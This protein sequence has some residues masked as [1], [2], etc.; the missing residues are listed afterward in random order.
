MSSWR[1]GPGKWGPELDRLDGQQMMIPRWPAAIALLVLLAAD[2]GA[3]CTVSAGAV[4]SALAVSRRGRVQRCR[5]SVP[6]A[7]PTILGATAVCQL[8]GSRRN[9]LRLRGGS[10]LDACL[11]SAL[12]RRL[13]PTRT[14]FSPAPLAVAVP[15]GS[16]APPA[17]LPG[18]TVPRVIFILGGPGAGKG[19]QCAKL[20]EYYHGVKHLSAGD[21][22]R[23]ER[24]SGSAQGDMINSYM[25]EGKI[26]PVA[27]TAGLLK[28][29]IDVEVG[30]GVDLFL[31]DGFPRNE[32]NLRGW[33]EI[34]GDT[35]QVEFMLLM[36]CSEEVMME[37]L[38]KRGEGSGRVDDNSDTIRK[39]FDV[40][41]SETM[42]VVTYFNHQDRLQR[43][44]AD[45]TVETVFADI[46]KV[47]APVARSKSLPRRVAGKLGRFLAGLF[48]LP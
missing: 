12:R 2:A 47:M 37:R 22:L 39:R 10:L 13:A 23:A 36:E 7:S 9:P 41:K 16:D 20:T 1:R 8:V 14:R 29:A 42:P 28:K 30:N 4:H 6:S 48:R 46:Q 15:R 26:I 40:Y 5:H 44:S 38:V 33:N 11:P 25:K 45:N 24:D 18:R 3:F 34:V 27:V 31:I 35:V 43:I 19:T 32:D 17:S 21:L